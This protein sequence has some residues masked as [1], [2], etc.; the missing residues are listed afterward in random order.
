VRNILTVALKELRQAVKTPRFMMAALILIPLFTAVVWIGCQNYSLQQSSY[1][2][3]LHQETESYKS[4]KDYWRLL[5]AFHT[6][7]RVPNP[8]A[9]LAAGVSRDLE[10]TFFMYNVNN[11]PSFRS[12]LLYNAF[13]RVYGQWDLNK[14]IMIVVSFLALLMSF[15]AIAGEKRNGTL[16]LVCANPLARFSIIAGKVL[17]L[18]LAIG[19]ILLVAL[20]IGA[21]IISFLLA[22]QAYALLPDLFAVVGMAVI[23]A[24][25]FLALGVVVSALCHR[26]M[27]ALAGAM[28]LWIALVLIIPQ[29][30]TFAAEAAHESMSDEEVN[31]RSREII[32]EYLGKFSTMSSGETVEERIFFRQSWFQW[33]REYLDQY[34]QLWNELKQTLIRQ[35]QTAGQLAWLSPPMAT[36]MGVIGLAGTNPASETM[37]IDDVWRVSRSYIDLLEERVIPDLRAA[38]QNQ[39]PLKTYEEGIPWQ[40][41][42]KVQFSAPPWQSRWE[43]F[44]HCLVINLVWLGVLLILA[45]LIFNRYDVR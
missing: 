27:F 7:Y 17:G 15:D 28:A 6:A 20:L 26:P 37:A 41:F 30:I 1:E 43:S 8:R 23:Y 25:V 45:T 4:I 22:G 18:T 40:D 5:R 38:M 16:K 29:V 24:A 35:E 31:E 11:P 2:A 12:M 21:V 32:T 44:L 34:R 33:T 36:N 10:G 19:A 3:T 42:E 39:A 14:L 9:I 13:S